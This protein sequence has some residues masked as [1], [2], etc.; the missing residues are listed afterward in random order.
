MTGMRQLN[1]DRR[2]SNESQIIS[3]QVDRAA[4]IFRCTLSS[5]DKYLRLSKKAPSLK[6]THSNDD[7]KQQA[8]PTTT[9]VSV[10]HISPGQ[11]NDFVILARPIAEQ[12]AIAEFARIE[13]AQRDTLSTA[14]R[15]G[16]SEDRMDQRLRT[17][18][19]EWR[20]HWLSGKACCRTP[21]GAPHGARFTAR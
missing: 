2:R 1:L 5:A 18:A 12:K 8:F 21:I 7:R 19:E 4:A 15:R 10:P 17:M 6:A 11:I 9:C 13:S 14:S 16:L 3:R 20:K